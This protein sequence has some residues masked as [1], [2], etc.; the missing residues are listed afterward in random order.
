MNHQSDFG[1]S[2]AG[3]LPGG[4]VQWSKD[5][6]AAFN[7]GDYR[8]ALNIAHENQRWFDWEGET[9]EHWCDEVRCAAAELGIISAEG[10]L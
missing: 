1:Y 7:R 4:E 8:T 9:P 3:A 2:I 5:Y 10:W 6:W